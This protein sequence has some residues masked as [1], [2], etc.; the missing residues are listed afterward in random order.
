MLT[1]LR[2][3]GFPDEV[4]R[5]LSEWALTHVYRLPGEGPVELAPT[6]GS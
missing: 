2:D 4:T 6:Q 3:S 1:S 5:Q